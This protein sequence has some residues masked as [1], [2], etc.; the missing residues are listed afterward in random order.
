MVKSGPWVVERGTGL[1]AAVLAAGSMAFAG[2]QVWQM[3]DLV[4]DSALGAAAVTVV[5]A[6]TPTL[7][8]HWSGQQW[9]YHSGARLAPLVLA[10]AAIAFAVGVAHRLADAGRPHAWMAAAAFTFVAGVGPTLTLVRARQRP[11]Y[12]AA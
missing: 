11:T 4:A 9:A 7:I 12:V 10:L 2:Y 6:L 8:A 1:L 3:R 5:A